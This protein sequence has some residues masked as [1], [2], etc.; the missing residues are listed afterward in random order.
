MC[1]KFGFVDDDLD[2]IIMWVCELNICWG[3]DLMYW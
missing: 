3:F 2:I 1:V